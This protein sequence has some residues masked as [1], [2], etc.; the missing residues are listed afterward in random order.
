MQH[1][2]AALSL[3]VPD[4]V[5]LTG[6]IDFQ[7]LRGDQP[8]PGVAG[9]GADGRMQIT[10][11]AEGNASIAGCPPVDIRAG[12]QY[13]M[14]SSGQ[15]L[16]VSG[17]LTVD[18]DVH[19]DILALKHAE[20]D[21]AF[22]A[23][24]NYLYAEASGSILIFD[25]QVKGFLGRTTQDAVLRKVDPL[26]D[27]VLTAKTI[28]LPPVST[29]NPITGFYFNA[30]GDVVLNRLLGIPDDVITLKGRGGQGRFAF[31][32]FDHDSPNDLSKAHVIP[33]MRWDSGFSV[34]F[35]P[36]TAGG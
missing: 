20:F 22:G 7:H 30:I 36:V 25:A 18:S 13:T 33:G 23:L 9:A 17:S 3:H 15:P 35:G 14:N 8:V 34:S 1:I 5:T 16:G 29:A 24:D 26:L 4:P 27:Q 19:F 28:N 21:F 32:S 12:G 6:S 10:V 2:N 31:V 11:Q